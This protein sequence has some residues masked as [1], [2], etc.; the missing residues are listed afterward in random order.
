MTR[1]YVI[2][3]TCQE[4]ID[5]GNHLDGISYLYEECEHHK[6]RQIMVFPSRAD[7]VRYVY[8]ELYMT[9][10]EVIIIPKEEMNDDKQ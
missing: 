8:D 10:D 5:E 2:G 3:R 6:N 1:E 7:A 9:E 4:C